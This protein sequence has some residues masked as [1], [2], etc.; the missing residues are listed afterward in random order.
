MD[1]NDYSGPAEMVPSPGVWV[2]PPHQKAAWNWTPPG[3]AVPRPERM[4]RIVQLWFRTP[5]IDRWAYGWMWH[6]GGWDVEVPRWEVQHFINRI[7]DALASN[8]SIDVLSVARELE[9]T[10]KPADAAKLVEALQRPDASFFSRELFGSILCELDRPDFLEPLVIAIDEVFA[11]GHDG[12]GLQAA[13]CG[14]VEA[15]PEQSAVILRGL[16][17]RQ[18]PEASVETIDWLLAY[19]T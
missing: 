4:P 13:L 3:G 2:C 5:F 18:P 6:R 7:H 10:V 9:R 17:N 1:Q 12:D 14:L 19:C 11:Y 16:R 15:N 8:E